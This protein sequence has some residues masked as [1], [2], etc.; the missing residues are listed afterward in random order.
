[1]T[2]ADLREGLEIIARHEP[3]GDVYASH[4]QLTVCGK[5]PFTKEERARLKRLGFHW[6]ASEDCWLCFT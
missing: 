4:D 5:L 6:D 2:R 3:D 1:M